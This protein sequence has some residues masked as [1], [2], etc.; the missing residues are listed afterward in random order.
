MAKLITI[1]WR[2]IPSQVMVRKGRKTVRLMLAQRFQDAIDRAA[3]RAGKGSSS[4]YLSEWR[5]ESVTCSDDDLD[6]MAAQTVKRLEAA[7]T[8]EALLALIRA[9]GSASADTSQTD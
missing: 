4:A 9:K 1:F 3:M 7:H 6:Q 5:R 2:D 8:D